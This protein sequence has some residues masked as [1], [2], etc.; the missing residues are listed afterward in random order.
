MVHA[1]FKKYC[2]ASLLTLASL[3]RASPAHALV[4]ADT[5]NTIIDSSWWAVGSDGA[6]SVVGTGSHLELTQGVGGFAAPGLR[7]DKETRR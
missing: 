6:S 2:L 5:F 1:R 7:L 4:F 3:L